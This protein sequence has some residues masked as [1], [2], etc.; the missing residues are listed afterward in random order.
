ML[1]TGSNDFHIPVDYLLIIGSID[2]NPVL[3]T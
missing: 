3:D 1:L 2:F